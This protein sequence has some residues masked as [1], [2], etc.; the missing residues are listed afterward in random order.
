M[1]YVVFDG[2]ASY[3]EVPDDPDF[4][5]SRTGA[6]SVGVWM[7]PD[8]LTFPTPE[9]GKDYVHWLGKGEEP[10]QMEWTFRMYDAGDAERSGRISFYVY[11]PSAPSGER[12]NVGVGSYVQSPVTV[13]EWIHVVGV[14]DGVNVHLYRNGLPGRAQVYAGRVTPAHGN[15]PLRFG[16]RDR[17]SYFQGALAEIRIWN[18]A[19]TAAQVLALYEGSS[20]LRD[21]LIA[22]YLFKLGSDTAGGHDIGVMTAAWRAEGGP[23]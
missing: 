20:V 22:E 10:D 8:T 16:T 13:G 9:E 2:S 23:Q 3:C 19:L 7:R 5:V 21:G 4:G 18:R 11:N 17:R 15:A 12:T 1:D 6:L 14:A